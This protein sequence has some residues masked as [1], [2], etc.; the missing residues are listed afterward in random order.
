MR[1]LVLQLLLDS[2][3]SN[4]SSPSEIVTVFEFSNDVNT[5]TV[6]GTESCQ[7]SSVEA[8]SHVECQY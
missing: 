3:V 6:C 4:G 7:L 1:A 2:G 8:V 5:L